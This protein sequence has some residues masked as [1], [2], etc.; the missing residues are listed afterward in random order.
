MN[1]DPRPRTYTTNGKGSTRDYTR[2][3][4]RPGGVTEKTVN[5]SPSRCGVL[6]PEPQYPLVWL[7]SGNFRSGGLHPQ[8]VMSPDHTSRRRLSVPEVHFL[9][10]PNRLTPPLPLPTRSGSPDTVTS[11]YPFLTVPVPGAGGH[12]TKRVSLLVTPTSPGVR[13]LGVR[14]L[15]QYGGVVGDSEL[16]VP[17]SWRVTRDS[18]RC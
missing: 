15:R 18:R 16:G 7:R 6:R 1:V 14:H 5:E 10:S 13:R 2:N 9:S 4:S 17:C 8:H 12:P 11:E 3:S